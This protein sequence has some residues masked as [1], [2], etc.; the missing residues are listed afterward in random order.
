MRPVRRL[1]LLLLAPLIL[2]TGCQG[3]TDAPPRPTRV[4]DLPAPTWVY[5]GSQCGP[6]DPVAVPLSRARSADSGFRL[7]GD[8]PPDRPEG[9][10]VPSL[11]HVAVGLGRFRTGGHVVRLQDPAVTRSGETL[12][13]HVGV[14]GP[15]PGS[16]VTQVLT[17]P[18][19]VLRLPA[20]M[21]AFPEIEIRYG[22][23]S[24]TLPRSGGGPGSA[25][26]W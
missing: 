26:G 11:R 2:V 16:V 17:H 1:L 4:V 5:R 6:E 9:G 14:Q 7:P 20:A 13:V 24:W 18:C 22:G 21:A 3:R 19:G 15:P 23:R 25:P 12:V 10:G 8:L